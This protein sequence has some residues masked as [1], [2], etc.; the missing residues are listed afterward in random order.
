MKRK[1]SSVL[2]PILLLSI[3]SYSHAEIVVGVG[4]GID[5][6]QPEF[7]QLITFEREE[8][9]QRYHLIGQK[10]ENR[11]GALNVSLGV[12]EEYF[13]GFLALSF[14]TDLKLGFSRV[15]GQVTDRSGSSF[16]WKLDPLRQ[17]GVETKVAL[18]PKAWSTAAT[19]RGVY[20]VT[21]LDFARA[22]FSVQASG[23][24]LSD[25]A[26]GK[27]SSIGCGLELERNSNTWEFRLEYSIGL[28]QSNRDTPTIPDVQRL[29]YDVDID[30][31]GFSI[32]YS[33]KIGSE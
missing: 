30:H 18:Y 8:S 17:A 24:T 22:D 28:L 9:V 21:G 32:K 27:V 15:S 6:S 14:A 1:M 13:D 4:L 16:H 11:T 29:T 7:S 20:C 31:W 2:L 12:R 23:L 33:R 3:G 25:T 19:T 5:D 26:D 10:R